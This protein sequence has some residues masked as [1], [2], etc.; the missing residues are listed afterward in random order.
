MF[1]CESLGRLVEVDSLHG[2]HRWR[3]L[4]FVEEF[5]SDRSSLT[6]MNYR[7]LSAVYL[8]CVERV[9]GIYL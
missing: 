7:G 4:M 8:A 2:L 6:G 9:G 3:I 5:L 1:L